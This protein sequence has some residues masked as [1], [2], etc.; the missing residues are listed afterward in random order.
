MFDDTNLTL[1]ADMA[2]VK[3]SQLKYQ[4][5]YQRFKKVY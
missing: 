2:P 4:S 3:T 5:R 1:T